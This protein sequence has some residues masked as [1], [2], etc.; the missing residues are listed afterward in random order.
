MSDSEGEVDF[1]RYVERI[2]ML[3]STRKLK[4]NTASEFIRL[5]LE[6]MEAISMIKKDDMPTFNIPLGQ[7]NVLMRAVGKTL[8]EGRGEAGN[9]A[10]TL[11]RELENEATQRTSARIQ[12]GGTNNKDGDGVN[13]KDCDDVKNK[14]GGAHQ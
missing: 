2:Q 8:T 1:Q 9:M 6:S 3:A 12:N 11:P 5:G 7:Q 14:D 4:Q 13:T 10:D